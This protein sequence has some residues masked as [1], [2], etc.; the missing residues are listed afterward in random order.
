MIN[1]QWLELPMSQTNFHGPKDVR[2]IEV[3]L[4]IYSIYKR[5]PSDL[6]VC[7]YYR[8]FLRYSDIIPLHNTMF[9]KPTGCVTSSVGHDQT[10]PSVVSDV[11]LHCLLRTIRPDIQ[12]LYGTDCHH[13]ENTPIQIH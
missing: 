3:R 10:P 11:A 6:I 5:I 1:P 7:I 8:T 13:Y 2:A 12:G 9:L 4:Y